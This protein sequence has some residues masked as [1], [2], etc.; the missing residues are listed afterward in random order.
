MRA[1]IREID[2]KGLLDDDCLPNSHAPPRAGVNPER[3]LEAVHTGSTD[4]HPPSF[5]SLGTAT[6]D[7]GAKELAIQEDNMK[8]PQS[9]KM[10][11]P[12]PETRNDE[13]RRVSNQL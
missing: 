2:Q 3:W 1:Y 6:D 10:E 4:D 9:I 8:F 12:K 11:R 13:T 7:S 5:R